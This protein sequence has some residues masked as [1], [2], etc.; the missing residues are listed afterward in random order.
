MLWSVALSA[1]SD[2]TRG[3]ATT[4]LPDLDLAARLL[5]CRCVEGTSTPKLICLLLD[6]LIRWKCCLYLTDIR[7]SRNTSSG[8]KLASDFLSFRCF[9]SARYDSRLRTGELGIAAVRTVR[10]TP[11]RNFGQVLVEQSILYLIEISHQQTILRQSALFA[12]CNGAENAP[13]QN[14]FTQFS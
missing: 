8:P 1:A 2:T 12:L 6:S 5:T 11:L 10:L 13:S 3:G 14:R 7:L 4:A 9:G